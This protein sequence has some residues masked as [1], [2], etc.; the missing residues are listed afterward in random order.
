M[1]LITLSITQRIFDQNYLESF[2]RFVTQPFLEVN[3]M[4][5]IE[6]K[7]VQ[8][9]LESI[10]DSTIRFVLQSVNDIDHLA[11]AHILRDEE[12]QY[13][14]NRIITGFPDTVRS[15]FVL[16]IYFTELHETV[17]ELTLFLGLDTQKNIVSVKELCWNEKERKCFEIK[18][19]MFVF[20]VYMRQETEKLTIT[21]AG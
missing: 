6:I 15:I 4:V 14:Y 18:N 21:Q 3:H 8:L 17:Q 1:S 7:Y 19:M 16:Q 5:C 20:S 11:Y 2:I 12:V 13:P 9:E 10:F